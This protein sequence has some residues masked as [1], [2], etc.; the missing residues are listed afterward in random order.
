MTACCYSSSVVHI[1]KKEN[2]CLTPLK[3]W[4]RI[5]LTVIV[6]VVGIREYVDNK[7]AG[8]ERNQDE[9]DERQCVQFS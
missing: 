4:Q 6:A 3:R 1:E 9:N 8:D 2:L 7:N 5:E